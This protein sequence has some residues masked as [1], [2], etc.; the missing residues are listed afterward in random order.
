MLY[1]GVQSLCNQ[2][3]ESRLDLGAGERWQKGRVGMGVTQQL[4]AVVV[5]CSFQSGA[6]GS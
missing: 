3:R 1:L 4:Q 2:E 5:S 6:S